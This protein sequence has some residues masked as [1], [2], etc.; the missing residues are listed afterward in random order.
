M[1]IPFHMHG[2]ISYF[3][4]CLPM[5]AEINDCQ[6]IVFTS[7]QEWDPYSQTFAM[8]EKAYEKKEHGPTEGKFFTC[9]GS[10][11]CMNIGATSSHNWHLTVDATTLAHQWGASI[12]TANHTLTLTT[13]RVVRFY[14][15]EEFSQQFHTRQGHSLES[16]QNSTPPFFL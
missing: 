13:T 1:L 6:Q 14:P 15:A 3:A 10:D 12:E 11:S 9:G 7:E 2:C 8:L 16:P 5:Q 4:S